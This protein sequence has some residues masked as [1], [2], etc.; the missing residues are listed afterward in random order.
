M[1]KSLKFAQIDTRFFQHPH[2]TSSNFLAKIHAYPIS[3]TPNIPLFP[4]IAI[5]SQPSAKNS[6]SSQISNQAYTSLIFTHI[7]LSVKYRLNP[8]SFHASFQISNFLWHNSSLLSHLTL[9]SPNRPVF[10]YSLSVYVI[11]H[12]SYTYDYVTNT[13]SPILSFQ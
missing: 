5:I 10:V 12:I 13:C 11:I 3:Q 4:F 2:D 1:S 6:F 9:V 7:Y 8:T